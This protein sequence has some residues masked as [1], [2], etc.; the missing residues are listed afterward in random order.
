[1]HRIVISDHLEFMRISRFICWNAAVV[2]AVVAASS[3]KTI[4]MLLCVPT[5]VYNVS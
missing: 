4:S 2:A 1:M 5:D 3:S